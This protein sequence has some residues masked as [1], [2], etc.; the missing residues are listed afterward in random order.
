MGVQM[1]IEFYDDEFNESKL[2][3][4]Q[5]ILYLTKLSAT[6]IDDLLNTIIS[7]KTKADSYPTVKEI[8]FENHPEKAGNLKCIHFKSRLYMIKIEQITRIQH[9][10]RNAFFY[11]R[12]SDEFKFRCRLAELES[13]LEAYSEMFIRISNTEYVS[14]SQIRKIHDNI[15]LLDTGEE[16]P[17]SRSYV[18]YVRNRLKEY[19]FLP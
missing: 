15:V 16:C 10:G 14:I 1:N 19:D 13:V 18:I 5:I 12:N 2:V 7:S 4:A 6:E 3:K 17:I 8:I 11:F 9:L